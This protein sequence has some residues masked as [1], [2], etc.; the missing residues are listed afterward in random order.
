[1]KLVIEDD[2]AALSRTTAAVLAGAM[3]QDRRVNLSITA[4]ATPAGTYRLLAPLLAAR[5]ADLDNVH[6]YSF[7][8]I[9]NGTDRGVT[10]T[11]LDQQIFGPAAASTRPGSTPSRWTTPTG[12]APTC[13]TTAAWT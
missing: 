9:P 1:M 5:P 13:A 2:Y 4:G 10:R 11:S 6:F 3:L 12:S 7:D 8:E